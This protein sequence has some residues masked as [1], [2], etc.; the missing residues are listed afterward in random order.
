M[1]K[2]K[3][4]SKSSLKT[5]NQALDC[6]NQG[7]F[8]KAIEIYE[9]LASKHPDQY[10]IQLNLGTC[11]YA[12]G[13][14]M[15]AI[16]IF[17]PLHEKNPSNTH[18]LHCCALSYL[19]IDNFQIAMDFFRLLVKNDPKNIEGW[20]N[21]TYTANLL[22][23]NTDS[24][25]YAT[26]ALSM[27]PNDA[28]LFNNMGSALQNF[29]R[30]EDALI[31]YETALDLEPTNVNAIT[32]I[33]TINDKLGAYSEAINQYESALIQLPPNTKEEN[34]VLYRMSFPLLA[35]GNLKKG[36][37]LYERGFTIE[38]RR[39][40]IPN[41]IFNKP[42]WDGQ[43]INNKRLLVWREQGVGDEL[44][45]FS[46]IHNIYPSCSNII[47]ECDARLVSLLQRTFPNCLVR[48]EN[49]ENDHSNFGNEDFDFHI[50]AGSLCQIYR[51]DWSR[52]IK[53]KGYLTPEYALINKFKNLLAKYE[54]KL[55]VGISWRSGNLNSERNINYAAL[56]EWESIL[57]IPEIQFVNLQYGDCREEILNVKEHFGVDILT[58]DSLDIKN[59]FESLAGLVHNLDL[60][61]AASTFAAPFSQ[62]IGTPLK[63]VA[64]TSWTSL[65][66]AEW[67]WY[68]K[69][70]IYSPESRLTPISSVFPRLFEDLKQIK[71]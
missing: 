41:R 8:S 1:N 68:E 30:Y 42:K 51:S 22:K 29:H 9:K 66:K 62:A 25:Y 5:F 55:L 44:W 57:K 67:P 64:H 65:S 19:G 47:I 32:N 27:N 7:L 10:E 12:V 26:Q 16:E 4:L 48:K 34:E 61:I 11:Y 38:G 58:W 43:D 71:K 20:V 60:V 23:N 6:Q 21:L 45:F 37:E 15:N 52:F 39:G 13:R 28:R 31:C 36:W 35:S 3:I 18:L 24:L 63:L 50:A 53:S 70:D 46:L 14:F 2:R 17:H 54:G 69:V 59:D 40:R 56:S 33:A 49:I